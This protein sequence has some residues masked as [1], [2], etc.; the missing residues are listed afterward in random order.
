MKQSKQKKKLVQPKLKGDQ[1]FYIL[2]IK[3]WWSL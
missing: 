1:K 2:K 3:L